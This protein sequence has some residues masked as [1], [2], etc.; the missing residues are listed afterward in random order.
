M[1]GVSHGS[2]QTVNSLEYAYI[3]RDVSSVYKVVRTGTDGIFF[4]S[5]DGEATYVQTP[6]DLFSS[7]LTATNDTRRDGLIY[8]A[9][10]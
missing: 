8:C 2:S 9:E 10:P 5:V 7:P 4:A 3:I 6:S 1:N